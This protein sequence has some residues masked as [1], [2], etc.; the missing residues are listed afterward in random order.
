M[1]TRPFG[2]G[3]QGTIRVSAARKK[4]QG[5]VSG[6]APRESAADLARPNF[7]P[8]KLSDESRC[9]VCACAGTLGTLQHAL[10]CVCVCVC[11][12]ARWCVCTRHAAYDVRY[13]AL[14]AY[15]HVNGHRLSA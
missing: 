8:I 11:A 10:V 4:L 15:R 12:R 7:M 9:C 6:P 3:A 14:H 2:V 5:K 13:P 1:L